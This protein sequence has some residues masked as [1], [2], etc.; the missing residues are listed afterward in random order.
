MEYDCF[1]CKILD[2]IVVCSFVRLFVCCRASLLLVV[3]K[4]PKVDYFA[5]DKIYWYHVAPRQVMTS[6]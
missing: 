3:V 5:A 1:V 2:E 6:R 4:E